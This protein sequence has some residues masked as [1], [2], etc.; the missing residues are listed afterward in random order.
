MGNKIR[1]Q[2]AEKPSLKEAKL[3]QI[4]LNWRLDTNTV[5]N[6]IVLESEVQK[7]T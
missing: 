3:R 5:V 1:T 4:S 6:G 7:P 2:D